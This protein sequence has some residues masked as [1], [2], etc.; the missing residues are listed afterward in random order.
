MAK[1][2]AQSRG[3]LWAVIGGAVLAAAIVVGVLVAV[4]SQGGTA[5]PASSSP[6]TPTA[7]PTSSTSTGEVVDAAAVEAG[8]VPEPIT[9][10][11][12]SYLRAAIEAAGT[13]DTT[14]ATRDE[15]VTYLD[16]WFTPDPRF[17]DPDE[18]AAQTARYQLTMRDAVI[19]PDQ[20]W[21]SLARQ[22]G[23]VI[24]STMGEIS[25]TPVPDYDGDDMF[26]GTSDVVLTFTQTGEDGAESSYEEQVR[27]SAQVLCG[28]ASVPA[29]GS[30]QAAGDCKLI[31]YFDAALSD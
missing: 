21:D 27:V 4:T 28:E 11:P 29:P 17:Q 25:F 20:V 8:W 5:Q 14:R 3:L 1:Q 7:G 26:I 6:P 15:W 19:F 2:R 16:T 30:A 10:D 9:T 22:N 18:Q 23:R 31:R 12:E 13:V 24:A